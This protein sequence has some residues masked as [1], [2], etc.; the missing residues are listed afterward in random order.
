MDA[1]EQSD[2]AA[3]DHNRGDA[4]AGIAKDLDER[5]AEDR[6]D[7]RAD[8]EHSRRASKRAGARIELDEDAESES[9][10]EDHHGREKDRR[11]A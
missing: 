7:R 1:R 3:R 11:T 10:G 9:M 4:E 6:A 2:S 8:H 5:T